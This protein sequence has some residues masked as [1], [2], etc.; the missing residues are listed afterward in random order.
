MNS[1]RQSVLYALDFDGVIC[2]SAVELA[3]SGW[4]VAR[5][6]WGDMPSDCEAVHLKAYQVVRPVLETGY[7]SIPVMRLVQ[8]GYSAQAIMDDY[9]ALVAQTIADSGHSIDALKV[10]FGEYRD[11]WIRDDE[12]SWLAN[13][14]LFAGMRDKLKTL[15]NQTWYIVT[16]KQERF[17]Q[18]ILEANGIHI[19]AEH[20]YGLDRQMNKQAVLASLQGMYSH[21]QPLVFVEDRLPTLLGVQQNP[22]L[23][24]VQLQLVD[25]GYNT[26]A[27]REQAKAAGISVIGDAEFLSQ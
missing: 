11:Q 16:T 9:D 27:E 2:D 5:Q 7:E 20:I 18:K 10:R 4:Q 23:S 26:A 19:P 6:C 3:L 15:E 25:W 24:A 21:S 12:R 17:A 1:A 22:E 13:N 8:Q 14:P